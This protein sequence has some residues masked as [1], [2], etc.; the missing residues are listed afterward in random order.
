MSI[1]KKEIELSSELYVS[2]WSGEL[3]E[4][5]THREVVGLDLNID[6]KKGLAEFVYITND[7]E[8]GEY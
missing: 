7:C 8:D 6:T 2:V 4:T 5:E 1:E 3:R